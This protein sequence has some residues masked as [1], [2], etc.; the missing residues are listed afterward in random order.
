MNDWRPVTSMIS[1][2]IDRFPASALA[3]HSRAVAIGSRCMRTLARPRAIVCS[4][5]SGS[6]SGSGPSGS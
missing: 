5:G 1:S 4:P 2:R 6:I 3:R